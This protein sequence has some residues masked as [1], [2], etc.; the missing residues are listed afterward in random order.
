MLNKDKL[1]IAIINGP[2]IN[3][4]G[5]REVGIYGEKT[6]ETIE[7]E[8][9]KH[10]DLQDVNLLFFQSNH[11]GDIVDFIQKYLDDMDG[12][13]INPAAFTKHGYSV[14]DALTAKDLPF[15]EVHL[16]NIFARGSWH[17]ETIFA[18]RAIGHIN[19]FQADVYNLGLEAL[20]NY[21]RRH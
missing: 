15:V 11:E 8:L 12:V 9:K 17:A 1:T 13:V 7:N 4:L 14:L 18:E 10:A 16:S 21:L 2:N 6:L 3:I 5:R 19:G 20:I